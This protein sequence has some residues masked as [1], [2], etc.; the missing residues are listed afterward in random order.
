MKILTSRS[1]GFPGFRPAANN[2]AAAP[3]AAAPAP[4]AGR[5]AARAALR[6]FTLVETLA[7][8]AILTLLGALLMNLVTHMAAQT[9]GVRHRAEARLAMRPV[10]ARLTEEI[11]AAASLPAAARALS[12]TSGRERSRLA[13]AVPRAKV[14]PDGLGG[15]T[16][17]VIYEWEAET[18]HLVRAEY[19]PASPGPGAGSGGTGSTAASGE[20]EGMQRLLSLSPVFSGPGWQDAPALKTTLEEARRQPLLTKVLRCEFRVLKNAGD[21]PAGGVMSRAGSEPIPAAVALTL[22]CAVDTASGLA[23]DPSRALPFSTVVS[24]TNP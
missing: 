1:C 3:P 5:S 23:R 4:A 13:L 11:R 7:G 17:L 21:R 18:G 12:F 15:G 22:A 6:G 16:A 9:D 20:G 2:T 14:G 19:H 24:L 10:M 8:L